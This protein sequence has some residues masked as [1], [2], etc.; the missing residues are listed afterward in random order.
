MAT[1]IRDIAVKTGTYTD[2]QGQEKG[3][4]QN[5]G[6]L[7][8]NDDGGEFII[9]NRWFNP[10][11]VPNPD[12]KDSVLLSCFKMDNQNQAAPQQK[13]QQPPAPQGGYGYYDDDIPM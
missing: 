1:K 9:L 11:G 6:S 10:A 3:R 5:V 12:N 13:P 8:R 7:M 2:G 4:W